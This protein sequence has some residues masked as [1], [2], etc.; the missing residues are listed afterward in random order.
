MRHVQEH[1]YVPVQT[2]TGQFGVG[3]QLG[4][5]NSAVFASSST[6]EKNDTNV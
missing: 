1:T 3:S 2:T 5:I 4:L 6:L